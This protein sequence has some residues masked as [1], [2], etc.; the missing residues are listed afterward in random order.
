MRLALFLIVTCALPLGGLNSL[1]ADI[2][3][4]DSPYDMAGSTF[5]DPTND[6]LGMVTSSAPVTIN[7]LAGSVVNSLFSI[8]PS[9]GDVI[10]RDLAFRTRRAW[11]YQI[12]LPASGDPAAGLSNIQ[13][14]GTVFYSNDDFERSDNLRFLLFLNGQSQASARVIT[15]GIDGGGSESITLVPTRNTPAVI[16]SAIVRTRAGWFGAENESF[17]M[18]NFTLS[19]DF[20]TS[21][22][23]PSS[24]VPILALGCLMRRRRRPIAI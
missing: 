18:N 21:I 23:E 24:L 4:V 16:T 20:V 12:A 2:V 8:A 7:T 19:A 11:N 1:R 6:Y 9:V 13:F 22:P 10:G 14:A 5:A 3:S 17:L 15:R